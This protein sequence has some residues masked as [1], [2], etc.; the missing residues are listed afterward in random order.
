MDGSLLACGG[1]SPGR[2]PAGAGG[3]SSDPRNSSTKVSFGYGKRLGS[4]P[5]GGVA[6]AAAAPRGGGTAP[7]WLEIDGED[8]HP[9]RAT[10]I[11]AIKDTRPRCPRI[12]RASTRNQ[13][14][15]LFSQ[16]KLYQSYRVDLKEI[17]EHHYVPKRRTSRRQR[18]IRDRTLSGALSQLRRS[19]TLTSVSLKQA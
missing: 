11:A 18:L 13:K 9:A 8:E 7:V 16:R 5:D 14:N 1:G 17:D 3:G 10:K 2:L 15:H 19:Q 6:A 12:L 4:G